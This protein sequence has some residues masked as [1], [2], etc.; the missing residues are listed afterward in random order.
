LFFA[1]F[2]DTN[3]NMEG[4]WYECSGPTAKKVRVHLKT[5]KL[6]CAEE[7]MNIALLNIIPDERN[8]FG[9]WRGYATFEIKKQLSLDVI[10]EIY[11]LLRALN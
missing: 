9:S 2:G 7:T 4:P 11:R 10:E 5:N 6:D 1:P 3:T 8:D